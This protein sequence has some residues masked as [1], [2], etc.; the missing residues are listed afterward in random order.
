MER[1][2]HRIEEFFNSCPLCKRS[3]SSFRCLADGCKKEA[4]HLE[5]I[6]WE[7]QVE[8]Q[9]RVVV[10]LVSPEECNYTTK[11]CCETGDF[12]RTWRGSSLPPRGE[13]IFID[14]GLVDTF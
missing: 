14:T 13:K 7:H 5:M 4:E 9:N 1:D 2:E 8:N 10:D 6:I 12:C 11:M 3:V